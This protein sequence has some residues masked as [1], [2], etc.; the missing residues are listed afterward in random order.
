MDDGRI[1]PILQSLRIPIAEE[2][3]PLLAALRVACI[4]QE[5]VVL[6]VLLCENIGIFQ[7]FHGIDTC[8]IIQ[9]TFSIAMSIIS[10]QNN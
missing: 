9:I 5:V 4:I 1:I 6:D 8:F 7:F 10:Y 3:K 2:F